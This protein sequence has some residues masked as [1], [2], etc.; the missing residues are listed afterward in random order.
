MTNG[1]D[2]SYHALQVELRRRFSKGLLLQGSY[3]WSK[4]LGNVFDTDS[5]AESTPTTFRNLAHDKNVAPRDLRHGFKF[6]Y[7]Y[8]L[9]WGPGRA[10]LNG[11]PSFLKKISEGWQIGG[12]TRIQSGTPT[13]ILSGRQT[14]NNNDGGV[15]LH[16]ITRDQ[17]QAL[18][19]V[20]KTSACDPDCHGVV[21]WLP[22]DIINNTL[23]AFEQG[24]KTLADL[25]PSKPY[26]GPPTAP[27][28]LG[29]PLALYG[30]WTSRFDIS[31]MKR[32]KITERTNV[33]FRVQFLNAFN[34][35]N[36]TIRG[37]GTDSSTFNLGTTTGA[38]P[39]STFG[40]TTNAFRDFTVSGTNDPGGRLIE[41]QLR[42]NF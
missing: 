17:L 11:G 39:G 33:E 9:P 28:E 24:G 16:N 21:Y 22:Q 5:A 36:I 27:G 29:S 18:V 37:A 31:L 3:V 15:V 10:L 38:T 32:T 26:I 35:S 12:V 4:S 23:A 25:D 7:I 8:E 34:Q 1:G 42:F 6:D 13:M 14:F 2:S 20:R 19:K 40:Q 41:F 30:P